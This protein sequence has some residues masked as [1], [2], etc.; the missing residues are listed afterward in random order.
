MR[1]MTY[2][3][4]EFVFLE[5]LAH[6]MHRRWTAPSQISA[7]KAQC[8]LY[9]RAMYLSAGG[10]VSGQSSLRSFRRPT[11]SADVFGDHQDMVGPE[12]LANI[13]DYN[14]LAQNWDTFYPPRNP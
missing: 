2:E 4:R 14:G 3:F 7:H 8:R 10:A 9:M 6:V 5:G 13:N 1:H 12:G 11:T